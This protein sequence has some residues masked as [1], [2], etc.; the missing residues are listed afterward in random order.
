MWGTDLDGDVDDTIP[1]HALTK[2]I[3]VPNFPNVPIVL[4]WWDW[5]GAEA[6]DYIRVVIDGT[7]V[8][9]QY[10]FDQRTW[11]AHTVESRPP[12]AAR[13]SS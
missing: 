3:D 4:T 2:M 8:Y 9:E 10:D 1:S 6:A 5:N 13:P 11:T 12:G 7:V